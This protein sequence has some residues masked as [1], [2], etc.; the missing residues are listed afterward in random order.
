MIRS[1]ACKVARAHKTPVRVIRDVHTSPVVKFRDADVTKALDY[2]RIRKID[3]SG[4][5]RSSDY[6]TSRQQA[7]AGIRG[8]RSY[9]G[10]FR[11]R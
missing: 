5:H 2:A 8:P 9:S 3:A 6:V 7:Q 10:G 1:V 4:R 11:E